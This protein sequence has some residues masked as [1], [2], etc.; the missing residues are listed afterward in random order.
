MLASLRWTFPL[1]GEIIAGFCCKLHLASQ[2]D[3]DVN[4]L[5]HR[6]NAVLFKALDTHA[7]G[8]AVA[9]QHWATFLRPLP[10]LNWAT[11]L[12]NRQ[13]FSISDILWTACWRSPQ[14]AS[15][16]AWTFPEPSSNGDCDVE[17]TA[18]SSPWTYHFNYH[19]FHLVYNI[20]T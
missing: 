17:K 11:T 18:S 1:T 13:G 6:V 8:V 7:L 3:G 4:N 16:L 15:Q 9:Y 12:P 5:L 14:L 2:R 10:L 20:I 19:H